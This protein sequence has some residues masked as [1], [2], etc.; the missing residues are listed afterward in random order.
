MLCIDA[1]LVEACVRVLKSMRSTAASARV[2]QCE[3]GSDFMA[4]PL[5]TG[6]VLRV[7]RRGPGV[8]VKPEQ[9]SERIAVTFDAA[10]AQLDVGQV[11]GLSK[12]VVTPPLFSAF[13]PFAQL[14]EEIRK[15]D[16]SPINRETLAVRRM[17]GRDPVDVLGNRWICAVR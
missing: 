11:G 4:F 10:H 2:G 14:F 3:G 1:L 5:A 9:R 13:D 15:H 6:T 8:D 7:A 12:I 16:V 17:C